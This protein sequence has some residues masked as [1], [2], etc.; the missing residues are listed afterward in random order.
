MKLR[1]R[2]QAGPV[3]HRAATDDQQV[4]AAY[5]DIKTKIHNQLID[6]LE[7][8]KLDALEPDELR[9]ELRAVITRMLTASEL[10]LNRIERERLVQELLDEVT[11]LGPL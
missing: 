8:S 2:L 3:A 4:S 6:D 7:L 1:D 9:A 10:P 11:G 5:Q